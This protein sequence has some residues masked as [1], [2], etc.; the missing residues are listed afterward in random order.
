[1]AIEKTVFTATTLSQRCFEVYDWLVANADGHDGYFDS[2]TRTDDVISCKIGDVT[3]VEIDCSNPNG[4][5]WDMGI[6]LANNTALT[7]SSDVEHFYDCAFKTEN[8]IVLCNRQSD[9]YFRHFVMISKSDDDTIC[10]CNLNRNSCSVANFNSH[11]FMSVEGIVISQEMTT[12]SPIVY[13]QDCYSAGMLLTNFT[14]YKGIPSVLTD[15][16]GAKYVY[17][18]YVALK[19]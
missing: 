1:M 2:I 13:G 5:S 3:A 8:G 6:T 18:G 16:D 10:F 11:G 9:Q 17:N 15:S 12:F 4:Y 7:D 19:E 14:Q